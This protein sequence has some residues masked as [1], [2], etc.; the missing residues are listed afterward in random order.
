MKILFIILAEGNLGHKIDLET[1]I[2]T[3]VQEDSA[4]S[5][6]IFLKSGDITDYSH[7]NRV[8]TVADSSEYDQILKRTILS[9]P[10][11]LNH[12]IFDFVVRCNVSTYFNIPKL[13]AE[14]QISSDTFTFG[15]FPICLNRKGD[16]EHFGYFIS[17]AA[18]I[19]SRKAYETLSELN[20]TD[21]QN[22]PDDVAISQ[23]MLNLNFQPTFIF[24]GDVGVT[25]AYSAHSIIRC[26]SSHISHAASRRMTA[27]H[28]MNHVKGAK[29][30]L[31]WA[32]FSLSEMRYF[33]IDLKNPVSFFKACYS[34]H[35]SN[36]LVRTSRGY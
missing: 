28:V 24:R 13:R 3:W 17:G 2:N 16:S 5:Q 23:Y 34:R 10:F 29:F 31:N 30:L 36:R 11:V 21:Y 19:F 32:K 18:I 35:M 14:L 33:G 12:F 25:H 9:I 4:D 22:L 27:L 15:G 1:C 26:K 20:L 6:F 8:L 7:Q